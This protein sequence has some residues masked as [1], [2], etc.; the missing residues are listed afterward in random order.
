MSI[1]N[2]Y[3]SR[4]KSQNNIVQDSYNSRLLSSVGI[5]YEIAEQCRNLGYDSSITPESDFALDM[6]ER[7]EKLLKTPIAKRLRELLSQTRTEQA[8]LT[9][10]EEIALGKFG[11]ADTGQLLDLATRVG[12]AVV[13]EG[14]TVAP[15]Q[16][17][18]TVKIK[19]ND[20]GSKYAA[21][22]F[23]GPIRAAG[24]TEAAFCVVIADRVRKALGL[25]NYR[26]N[27]FGD[28]EVGRM[29]EELRIYE[30]EVGNFQFRV[31]DDD[32]KNVILHVPVEIDGIETNPVEVT[33]HRGMK[34]INSDKIRGGA[35]RVLN[36]GIIG[37]ARKLSNL[38]ENLSIHEWSWLSEL[39][40]G[41]LQDS[42]GKNNSHFDDVISGRPVLSKPEQQGGFRLRYGRSFNTGISAVGINPI[43]AEL[44][45]YPVVVGTQ[46]KMS[47]PGKGGTIAFVDTIEC[48]TVRLKNGSVI[49]VKDVKQAKSIKDKVENILFMGDI[50]ISFGDFLENNTKLPQ[51]GY[52]EEFWAREIE[53]TLKTFE[54]DLNPKEISAERIKAILTDPLKTFPTFEEAVFL[55]RGL[56]VGLHPAYTLYWDLATPS[57]ILILKKSLK[58]Q[59]SKLIINENLN[60]IKAIL[61]KI[62]A[63]HIIDSETITVE[64]NIS[65]AI[66][67]VLALNT[68]I[69][70][71]SE[72]KDVCEL[73]SLLAGFP[74]R[75]KSSAFIGVRVG[76]PEKAALR[77]MKPPVHTLFPIETAG[78][79]SRDLFVASKNETITVELAN[80]ACEKCNFK[81]LSAKCPICGGNTIIQLKCPNC[82]KVLDTEICPTCRIPG[83]SYSRTEYPIRQILAKTFSR[84]H[85]RPEPPLRGI[86]RLTNSIRLPEPLE[87]GVLRKKY[88]LSVYK[89][90]TIRFDATNAPLTHA[91]AAMI[92]VS[93]EALRKLGYEKDMKGEPLTS[94]D[95][96][97]ELFVQ[98]IVI[99]NKAASCLLNIANFIDDLL[100]YIYKQKPFYELKSKEDLAGHLIIG[101]APHTSVGII[102]RIIGFTDSQVCFAHPFWHSAKRRDCDGDADSLI[103]L[104]DVL[105]NFSK[106]YLPAQIGGLMDAPL[107][108]QPIIIPHE[109][110]R[111]AHNLDI[112]QKYPL[113]FYQATKSE[114]LPSQITGGMELVRDRL[115]KPE[116]F[117]DFHFTHST[118]NI[119]VGPPNSSYSNTG[120]MAEKL[121]NQID[122]A[123]KITAVNPDEVVTSVLKT[124]L[125]PDIIGNLKAYTSQSFRCKSCDFEYRRLPVKGECLDCGGELRTTVSRGAVEKYL[126]L[127]AKLCRE[128]KVDEY[129]RSRFEVIANEL[130][131]LFKS[132]DEPVQS[133]LRTFFE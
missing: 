53:T 114:P 70:I 57:E 6:A 116:Q 111:Q 2:D 67:S 21:I 19:S 132:E 5:V 23:A 81:S 77:K 82:E 44:L 50:L 73:L 34:R 78:G 126:K 122:L 26:A 38:L 119:T 97:F 94:K 95:Q 105:L 32:I 118:S 90:G 102:G 11:Y 124:H 58:I 103:L 33:M 99:P 120:T 92:N 43:I 93:L 3:I 36:D 18:S 96:L 39:Q 65:K 28:D 68:H 112:M 117:Y 87:K 108:I 130:S 52:V 131:M 12:L 69:Q 15:L 41:K 106:D 113:E 79:S 88:D 56:K 85:Y 14:I 59:E 121:Q 1:L 37:R 7:I 83:N 75:R 45:D 123:R 30:R 89:D 25:D 84:A 46:V 27:G 76:R 61:E 51:S 49:Q 17:I 91:T 129:T 60:E 47:M 29:I 42:D 62:G 72:W 63:P 98:D 54:I 109:I 16:G 24:G 20:D 22:S 9:I 71:P 40:G 8:A 64:E 133:D 101:L 35:L 31:S 100:L 4:M 74:I 80:L 55:A 13:T 115:K 107:I 66:V 125:L 86:Q 127:A 104:F 10:A 48:P 110:Q 128:F